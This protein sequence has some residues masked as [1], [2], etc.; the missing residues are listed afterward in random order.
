MRKQHL[1]ERGSHTTVIEAAAPVLDFFA[2]S[3]TIGSVTV[4]PGKIESNVGAKSKSIK[5]K[6][7]N[8][9]VYEMVITHNGS[10]QEFKVFTLTASGVLVLA[11]QNEKRLRDWNINYL[12]MR[13]ANKSSAGSY[14]SEN[15]D[16]KYRVKK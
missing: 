1:N 3:T 4:S 10:R 11:L 13:Q 15:L 5:L 14:V 8:D 16:A 6:H 9:E 7:I 2:K 12:D